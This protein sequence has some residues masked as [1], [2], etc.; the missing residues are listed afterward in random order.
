MRDRRRQHTV[1][2]FQFSVWPEDP[3]QGNNKPNLSRIG[4]NDED[5]PDAEH[6]GD[7]EMTEYS[8]KLNKYAVQCNS[9]EQ[10]PG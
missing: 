1:L 4:A 2:M 7:T 9:D 5:D 8:N 6:A 10:I 3:I